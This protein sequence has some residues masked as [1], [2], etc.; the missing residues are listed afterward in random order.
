MFNNA[1]LGWVVNGGSSV[2]HLHDFDHA[3]IARSMGCRGVRV[4]D[5]ARLG[6]AL[7]EAFAEDALPTVVDV[8]ISMETSFRDVT[9]PLV[10]G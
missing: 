9:S 1:A 8:R 3:E 6:A 7:R 5:P 4:E 2:S 10:R